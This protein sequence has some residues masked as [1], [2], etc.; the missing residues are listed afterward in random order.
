[1]SK[2]VGGLLAGK[3]NGF[4]SKE[5]VIAGAATIP[6]LSTTLAVAFVGREMGLIDDI[7]ITAMIVL[8]IATTFCGP[9]LVKYLTEPMTGREAPEPQ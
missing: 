8:S 4:T 1:L 6:Q 5:S 2:F 7:L 3:A 9:I